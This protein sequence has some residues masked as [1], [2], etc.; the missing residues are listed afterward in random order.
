MYASPQA[1]L[2]LR[3]GISKAISSK[4]KIHLFVGWKNYSAL[5]PKW[6]FNPNIYPNV[7]AVDKLKNSTLYGIGFQYN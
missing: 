4:L 2:R 6:E 7:F 5:Q 3:G 1:I